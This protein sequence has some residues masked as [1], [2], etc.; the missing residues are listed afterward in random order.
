M[1]Q[2]IKQLPRSMCGTKRFHNN[3]DDESYH[4]NCRDTD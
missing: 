4:E 1:Q 2:T 3:D